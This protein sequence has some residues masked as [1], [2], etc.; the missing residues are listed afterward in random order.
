MPEYT[1]K[2]FLS[3]ALSTLSPL[4]NQTMPFICLFLKDTET[5]DPI[6]IS[7]SFGTK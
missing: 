3:F 2:I 1:S 4:S 6:S 5:K 7:F